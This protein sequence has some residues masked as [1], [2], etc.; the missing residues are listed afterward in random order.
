[1]FFARKLILVEG[2][3][4]QILL[5]EFFRLHCEGT[6]EK[7]GV[8]VLNVNG[9]SFVHF[10][11]VVRNGYFIRTAVLTDRD[12][13]TR[14]AERAEDLKTTFDDG[15]CIL[16]E[17][18]D[19]STFEKDLVEANRRGTGKATLLAALRRTR[20]VKGEHFAVTV[21]QGDLDAEAFFAEIE[22]Y[23]AAFAFNLLGIL[24]SERKEIAVPPY[25]R[26]AFQFLQCQ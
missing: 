2:I 26:R 22:S 10:L 17:I 13:G 18:S 24:A 12:T 14:T 5:P 1:M 20:P 16:V 9:V 3:S 11:K 15:N 6:P 25:I 8:T 21:G 7:H 4:E 23:K 19:T